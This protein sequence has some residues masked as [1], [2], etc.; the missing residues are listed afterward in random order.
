VPVVIIKRR[1]LFNSDNYRIASW[2]EA[3]SILFITTKKAVALQVFQRRL[4]YLSKNQGG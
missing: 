3:V 2:S 4:P 1:D